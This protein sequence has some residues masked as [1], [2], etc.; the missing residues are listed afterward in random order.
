LIAF[1]D[2][3]AAVNTMAQTEATS[4]DVRIGSPPPES[5]RKIDS[6]IQPHNERTA[7]VWSLGITF[8]R[9]YLI[10]LGKRK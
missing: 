4:Q 3:N 1:R 7:A 9:Q 6:S 8:P 2:P 5:T 10:T